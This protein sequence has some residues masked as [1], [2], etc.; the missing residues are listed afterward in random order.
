MRLYFVSILLFVVGSVLRTGYELLV[1]RGQLEPR[2]PW[3]VVVFAGMCALWMG[4]FSLCENDP[5]RWY[6]PPWARTLGTGA[7]ALGSLL[8]IGGAAQLLLRRPRHGLVTRGLFAKLRHPMYVGFA[9]WFVGYPLQ[10]GSWSGWLFG[11]LGGAELSIWYRVEESQLL[12]RFGEE[13][14]AYRS[15]TWC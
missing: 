13:Y 1:A 2:K 10:H 4:W 11:M 15:R 8:V 5:L 6:P 9:L 12:R 7:T 3:Q 14:L